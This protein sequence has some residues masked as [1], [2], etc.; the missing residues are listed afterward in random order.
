MRNLHWA[1][2][3]GISL[4]NLV[5]LMA[6]GHNIDLRDTDQLKFLIEIVVYLLSSLFLLNYRKK[7]FEEFNFKILCLLIFIQ[8]AL[9]YSIYS[10]LNVDYVPT[11]LYLIYIFSAFINFLVLIIHTLNYSKN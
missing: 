5:L 1:L 11:P 3:V 4:F 8:M 10:L 2:L 6:S 9:F 7:I